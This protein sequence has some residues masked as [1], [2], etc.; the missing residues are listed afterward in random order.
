MSITIPRPEGVV[1]VVNSRRRRGGRVQVIAVS[2]YKLRVVGM[3]GVMMI[4]K[5]HL[6]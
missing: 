4:G 1:G 6:L 5:G 3:V 2:C